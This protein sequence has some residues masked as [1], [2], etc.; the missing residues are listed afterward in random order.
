[1]HKD[2]GWNA[3]PREAAVVMNWRGPAPPVG[4]PAAPQAAVKGLR[5]PA[6]PP[7]SSRPRRRVT[8][9]TSPRARAVLGAGQLRLAADA[10]DLDGAGAD[11]GQ[12]T[13]DDGVPC[14]GAGD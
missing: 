13:V 11:V 1:M 7:T 5:A 8:T 9:A 3:A 4:S 2:A 6:A 12:P 10:T 14:E